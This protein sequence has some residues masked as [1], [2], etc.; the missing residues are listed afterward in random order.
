MLAVLLLATMAGSVTA[1][2]L[3][4]GRGTPGQPARMN[5]EPAMV[6]RSPSVALSLSNKDQ[7]TEIAVLKEQNKALRDFQGSVLDTVYWALGG[8]L[9]LAVLLAG[10]SWFTN[11]KL[12]EKDKE[13]LMKEFQDRLAAAQ[14]VIKAEV[15]AQLVKHSSDLIA[16]VDT[17]VANTAREISE[18]RTLASD[19][20]RRLNAEIENAKAQNA[21]IEA[22]IENVDGGLANIELELRFVEERVWD[23]RGV[24][25]N[26]LITQGQALEVAVRTAYTEYAKIVLERMKNLLEDTL[27][28]GAHGISK[29]TKESVLR[30]VAAVESGNEV[31]VNEIR[32]L[33]AKL[34]D[35]DDE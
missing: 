33:F 23:T 1:M 18:V 25:V 10:F 4:M 34:P 6:S 32:D 11:F 13:T 28:P 17:L 5:T 29:G 35:D 14:G 9:A 27:V 24:P 2:T 21:K 30:S 12:Y 15:A 3:T 26:V 31:I 19:I 16:R 22:E 7:T 8:I 20:E